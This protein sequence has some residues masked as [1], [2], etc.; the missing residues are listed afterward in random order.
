MTDAAV[1][2]LADDGDEIFTSDPIDLE[3]LPPQPAHVELVPI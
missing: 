3:E 1:V 2:L